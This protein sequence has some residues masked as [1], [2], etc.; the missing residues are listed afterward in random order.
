MTASLSDQSSPKKSKVSRSSL[1]FRSE[2]LVRDCINKIPQIPRISEMEEV[3]SL[4]DSDEN[5]DLKES[6]V[7]G[8][9]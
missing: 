9:S 8:R 3:K 6:I 5:D 4:P 7:L 2:R 1:N